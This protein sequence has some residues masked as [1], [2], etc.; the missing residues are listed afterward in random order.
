MC[1]LPGAHENYAGSII[2]WAGCPDTP[3]PWGWSLVRKN[4]LNYSSQETSVGIVA[5]GPEGG[6]V[7][8]TWQSHPRVTD[9]ESQCEARRLS[10]SDHTPK[11]R[12][13][14]GSNWH[15]RSMPAPASH[16][17]QPRKAAHCVPPPFHL[18]QM[19]PTQDTLTTCGPAWKQWQILV[20]HLYVT[21]LYI[22][23][24][25]F[26]P[27][28]GSVP[29]ITR[30]H[31]GFLQSLLEDGDWAPP[32]TTEEDWLRPWGP[33]SPQRRGQHLKSFSGGVEW[34]PALFCLQII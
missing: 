21:W 34:R 20:W 31:V 22:N 2:Q 30:E 3:L 18:R 5:A 1:Q 17:R 29:S 9:S 23:F 12:T 19:S 16:T 10:D 32:C 33:V 15:R 14:S 27:L 24:I 4:G 7:E 26:L 6:L 28:E 25:S 8:T 11:H 13:I